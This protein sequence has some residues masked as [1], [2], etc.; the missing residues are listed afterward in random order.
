MNH[1]PN[2]VQPVPAEHALAADRQ[3]VPPG[4]DELEKVLEVIVADVGVEE[5]FARAIHQADVHL[6]RVQVD[7][8]IELGGGG[9][10]FHSL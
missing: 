10:V 5:L 6:V 3:V 2:H 1:S 8:A 7:S 9:V 4:R